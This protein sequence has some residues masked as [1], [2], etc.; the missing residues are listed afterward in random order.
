MEAKPIPARNP[1]VNL[2]AARALP[3]GEWK[4]IVADLFA[5]NPVIYWLDFLFTAAVAWGS[6]SLTER[7]PALSLAE[8]SWF[9]VSVFAFYRAVLFIHELTHQ[10]RKDLPYFSLV[11]NL[12]MGIPFLFPS[13]MYRGVH[14]DHHRRAT[15]GTNEDG[16]YLPFG[17]SPI[18]RSVLYLGQSVLLP[19]LVVFRFAVISPLS[20]LHPRL[21]Q[22]VMSHCSSLN[23]RLDVQRNIPTSP[24]ELRNWTV[25]ESLCV[26]WVAAL[27]SLFASGLLPL[28][29]LRHIY[30]MMVTIFFVNSLRTV[31]AHRYRNR[32]GKD[33]TFAEQFE[34]S[35]NFEGNPVLSGLLA[36]VGLR[37]HALH[38]LFPSMPYHNLGAAHRRLKEKLPADSL[39][40]AANEPSFW[41]AV[42]TLWRNAR[43]AAREEEG[44][45]RGSYRV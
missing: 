42:H 33:L 14:I 7:A 29:T 41:S 31:V 6:F 24:V 27:A 26:A 4:K 25:Q 11:W 39:Y 8:I 17:A 3:L 12:V 2:A 23:I 19:F 38:H 43:T 22:Y 28:G 20:M 10:D 36:P 16:E 45:A 15:Y 37:Y 1:N 13:F 5:V 34:D 18:W 9:T 35:V 21:R 44:L 32:A 40:H 30:L